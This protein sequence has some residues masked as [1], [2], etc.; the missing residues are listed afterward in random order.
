M[1]VLVKMRSIAE[2]WP[3]VGSIL[4]EHNRGVEYIRTKFK[5]LIIHMFFSSHFRCIYLG[6]E[7]IK[8]RYMWQE[9]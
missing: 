6:R 7:D 4:H 8:T 2:L 9:T 3:A 1:E 5:Q